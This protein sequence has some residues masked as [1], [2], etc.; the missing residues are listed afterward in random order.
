VGEP[1]DFCWTFEYGGE[2]YVNEADCPVCHGAM[3]LLDNST[4][5]LAGALFLKRYVHLISLLPNPSIE[6]PPSPKPSP[7][8]FSFDG[9]KGLVMPVRRRGEG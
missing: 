4:V 8:A 5:E 2:D 3:F 9:G 7:Y 6:H 1:R